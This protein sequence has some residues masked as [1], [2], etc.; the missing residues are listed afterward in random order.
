[1]LIA[2]PPRVLRGGVFVESKA[3]HGGMNNVIALLMVHQ[4]RSTSGDV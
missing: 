1:M 3:A 2:T 4:Y